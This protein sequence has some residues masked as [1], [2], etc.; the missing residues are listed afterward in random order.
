M[1]FTS[2]TFDAADETTG[3]LKVRKALVGLGEADG[4]SFTMTVSVLWED[5][6]GTQR[7][8]TDNTGS[9]IELTEQNHSVL[10]DFGVA[11]TCWLKCTSYTSGT[12]KASITGEAISSD[13]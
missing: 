4:S 2:T 6:D 7:Y 8:A 10:I 11:V 13:R 5:K 9:V 12:A 1:P 3:K